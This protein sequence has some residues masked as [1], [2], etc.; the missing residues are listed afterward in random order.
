M[1]VIPGWEM[2]TVWVERRRTAVY[3]RWLEW[4]SQRRE[5][6]IWTHKAGLAQLFQNGGHWRLG[7]DKFNQT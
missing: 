6:S 5:R 2:V 1:S 4:A 7:T 3:A